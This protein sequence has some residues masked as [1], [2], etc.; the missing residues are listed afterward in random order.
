MAAREEQFQRRAEHDRV[1]REARQQRQQ[2]QV[3]LQPHVC[4]VSAD[5]AKVAVGICQ[6]LV[7]IACLEGRLREL[8]IGDRYQILGWRQGTISETL[9]TSFPNLHSTALWPVAGSQNAC[10]FATSM[11][12]SHYSGDECSACSEY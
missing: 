8:S 12:K 5:T 11:P 9:I 4:C 1:T 3:M 2:Q 6:T 7:V 10:R